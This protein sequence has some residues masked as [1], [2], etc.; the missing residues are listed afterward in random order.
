MES[1]HRKLLQT[2][3]IFAI[4][5]SRK[6][7]QSEYPASSTRKSEVPTLRHFIAQSAAAALSAAETLPQYAF[8]LGAVIDRFFVPFYNLNVMP[9]SLHSRDVKK[10]NCSPSHVERFLLG[11]LELRY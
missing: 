4:T 7:S 11:L 5:S 10:Q 1:T 3:R 8:L 6:F 9:V 2:R